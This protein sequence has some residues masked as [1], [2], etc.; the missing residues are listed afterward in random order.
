MPTETSRQRPQSSRP[1]T[2]ADGEH[3]ADESGDDHADQT[4][5]SHDPRPLKSYAGIM[6]SYGVLSAGLNPAP[7]P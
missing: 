7:A 2:P 4:S 5:H 3:S 6:A 1:E